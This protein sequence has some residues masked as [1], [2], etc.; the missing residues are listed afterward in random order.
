MNQSG[1]LDQQRIFKLFRGLPK[2][3]KSVRSTWGDQQSSK[4]VRRLPQVSKSVRSAWSE[5]QPSISV[6]KLPTQ[7]NQS[8]VRLPAIF[9]ISQTAASGI[10]ISQ[11]CLK[12]AT[13]FNIRFQETANAVKS[14]RAAWGDQQSSKS[15]RRLP[16]ASISVRYTWGD[17][18]SSKSVRRLPQVMKS[19]RVAWDVQQSSKSVRKLSQAM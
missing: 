16:Q 3:V 14:V 9:K 17:Q 19:F 2:A 6:Q 1:L 4:S 11:V 8:G 13:T 5:Q 7:W 18:Q 10:K 15:V 12:W